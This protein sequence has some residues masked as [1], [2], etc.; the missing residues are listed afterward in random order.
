MQ[1]LYSDVRFN[2]E[3]LSLSGDAL[4][5]FLA[6]RRRAI[7]ALERIDEEL[8]SALPDLEV[9][10]KVGVG[11]DMLDLDA[12][13]RHGVRLSWT[14]GTNARSVAELVVA[15]TLGVLRHIP[16]LDHAIRAGGWEQRKGALLSER[17]VGIVGYGAVGRE[18]A[19]LLTGFDC[20]ILIHDIVV[21]ADLPS[22][23]R[24][25]GL[26]EILERSDIVTLHLGLSDATRRIIDSAALA[27]MRAGAVLINT[28]RGE[29]VDEAALYDALASGQLAGAG[30][31][32]FMSEPP[33]GSPLLEL[34]NVVVTPHIGGSSEEAILAMGRAAIAG[35][36]TAVPI[37]RLS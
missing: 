14:R 12:M 21:Q 15:L 6:G 30:M 11:I 7:T 4:V 17:T 28:A 23:V 5:A 10:S 35:L 18:V 13:R 27:R 25:V 22:N 3:G 1:Q 33:V 20:P 2:D 34:P 16:A 29:L 9:I 19:R 24:Q 32:V 26:V 31:D 37:D 36:Q 8:L